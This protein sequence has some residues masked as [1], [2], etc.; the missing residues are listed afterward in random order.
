MDKRAFK[1][2][3]YNEISTIAKS[4]GNGN[5]L[6]IIDLL[7]NGEKSVEQI[8]NS[9][10]I[11]IANASQHLQRLLKERLVATNRFGNQIF[12]S[13]T[14]K[15]VYL[16]WKALCDLAVKVNPQIN[17]LM[18][19]FRNQFEVKES[20]T[21][22]T[23]PKGEGHLLLDVRPKEEFKYSHLRDAHSIPLKELPERLEELPKSKL[24]IA[25]CR[26]TFCTYADEA[27]SILKHNG[28]DAIRL[29]EGVADDKN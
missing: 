20:L 4:F 9:T 13:L 28:F 29:E 26:G 15:E 2:N 10:G 1:N 24:I 27:V 18:A 19:D 12:Y 6:E 3:V 11:S 23:L 21:L 8:A 17:E 14:S 16:T 7:A 22:E 5:R 25:Y